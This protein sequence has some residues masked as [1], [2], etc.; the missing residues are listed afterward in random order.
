MKLTKNKINNYRPEY[1][2]S[3][4]I[5]G[6]YFLEYYYY[7][8]II[9]QLYNNNGKYIRLCLYDIYGSNLKNIVGVVDLY[10][11]EAFFNKI[12]IY[13]STINIINRSDNTNILE[14]V[15]IHIRKSKINKLL[16]G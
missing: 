12:K 6:T 10:A 5:T 15:K 7:D 8:E 14:L 3:V 4:I 2:C 16:N 1:V 11:Y 9:F 13:K